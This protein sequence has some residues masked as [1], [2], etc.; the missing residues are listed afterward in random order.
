MDI[1]CDFNPDLIKYEVGD[2]LICVVS[3]DAAADTNP[4]E[5]DPAYFIAGDTCKVM[6][7]YMNDNPT[8]CIRL[9]FAAS[10]N[11]HSFVMHFING[12]SGRTLFVKK[13]ML[14]DED[15]FEGK[16]AGGWDI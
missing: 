9:G 6:D 4:D 16:L 7:I 11:I 8:E 5:A 13:H 14:T 1:G 12:E 15:I 10:G 2:T 3:E